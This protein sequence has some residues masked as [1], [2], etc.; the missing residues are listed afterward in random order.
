MARDT[1]HVSKAT[2]LMGVG[3]FGP[4]GQPAPV[5]TTVCNSRTSGAAGFDPGD[6]RPP[7]HGLGSAPR[8]TPIMPGQDAVMPRR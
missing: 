2:P 8:G 5:Q 3:G 7:G 1:S 4:T 6:D